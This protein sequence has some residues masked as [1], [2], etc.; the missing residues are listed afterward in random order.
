MWPRS[1]LRAVVHIVVAVLVVMLVASAAVTGAAR[2]TVAAAQRTLSDEVLPARQA[3]SDLATAYV[4]QE[5]GQRGFLFTGDPAFLQPYDQGL[6]AGDRL[7]QQLADVLADDAEGLALLDG[8]QEAGDRWRSTVAE[9]G[10]A[11]RREGSLTEEAA[12]SL[13]AEGK[14]QFDALRARIEV[15]EDHTVDLTEAQLGR[16]RRAQAIANVIAISAAVLAL[17]VGLST[18]RLLERRLNRPLHR[19]LT[20]V[21]VVADGDYDHSIDRSG[22]R[23][24]ALVAEAV[25]RM[26]VSVVNSGRE[27][28]E[29]GRE[30]AL[31][32]EHDRLAADLHDLTIQR[33]FGLGLRLSSAARR[34]PQMAEL[35]TP[36]VEETD[37][38]IRELR[39]VIFDLRRSG[40]E[41]DDSLRGRVIDVVEESVRALGF[42]PSLAFSGPVDTLVSEQA[43]GEVVAALRESLSNVARHAHATQAEVSLELSGESL[44]LTVKDDGVGIGPDSTRGN[45]LANL[46]ARA[47][48]LGGSASVA[49]PKG[50]GSVVT[51]QVPV[52]RQE[53]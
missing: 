8:V 40:A 1:S 47:Q 15:L 9:P 14:A 43:A 42:P 21:H 20:D 41:A 29:A 39:T 17:V 51:W 18:W 10:N 52:P 16:I 35:F 12:A 26:R 53:G 30:L 7:H 37:R 27:R 28:A 22:P 38:I 23:E 11:A 31:R 24:L 4:D 6:A 32:Q 13:A 48:R 2:A 46:S 3:A 50:G 36:L 49:A 45:G 33:V 25:D 19:L 34:H 44:V 5:T